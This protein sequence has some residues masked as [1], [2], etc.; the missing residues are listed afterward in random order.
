MHKNVMPFQTAFGAQARVTLDAIV[1]DI[2]L[3][4]TD[5]HIEIPLLCVARMAARIFALKCV[6]VQKWDSTYSTS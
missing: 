3:L 2:L 6:S 4:S 5:M 1:R